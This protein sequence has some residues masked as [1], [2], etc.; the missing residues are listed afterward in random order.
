LFQ[1]IKVEWNWNSFGGL[2]GRWSNQKKEHFFVWK[3][4]SKQNFH[5][6]EYHSHWSSSVNLLVIFWWS[7]VSYWN[8]SFEHSEA[9]KVIKNRVI[10]K[11]HLNL[12]NDGESVSSWLF[13]M[14]D[15]N[16]EFLALMMLLHES[17]KMI[18]MKWASLHN[19]KWSLKK[20]KKP[21][22]PVNSSF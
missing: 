16:I 18:I 17:L 19:E 1:L 15:W 8:K 10:K 13:L 9:L 2:K 3:I 14:T 6:K 12:A 11:S 20:I 22:K 7:F 4:P 5:N 21:L